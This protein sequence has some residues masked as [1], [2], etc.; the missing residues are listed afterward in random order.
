MRFSKKKTLNKKE[1]TWSFICSVLSI[2]AFIHAFRMLNYYNYTH[3]IP[4]RRVLMGSNPSV[5]PDV[6]FSNPERIEIGDNVRLGSRCHLWA[7]PSSGRI[8]IGNDVL[9][10][11][12][13]MLTAATY[14]YNDGSPVTDQMMD[15]SDI[16]IGDDVWLGTRV[17]VL[18]GV[19]IGPGAIIGAAAIVTR[20]V[21]SYAIAVG[22][23]ARVIGTRSIT[24]SDDN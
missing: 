1:R 12:E 3:V 24:S 16:I 2:G 19:S 7:G 5:S 22:M 14:R 17:V 6:V 10:G 23:P 20:D 4:K 11:P 21:P 8:I 9:F 13:V 15:E 18:P